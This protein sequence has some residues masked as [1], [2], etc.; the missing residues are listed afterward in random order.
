MNSS[1]VRSLAGCVLAFATAPLWAQG[2]SGDLHGPLDN[3]EAHPPLHFR[4]SISASPNGYG[5]AQIRHAYGFDQVAPTGAGQ[6]IAIIDAFG[7]GTI[8][9]DLNIFSAQYGLP[10]TTVLIYYPQG[11]P[12]RKDSGWALETSL[13]VEWAHAIAPAANI[14]LVV[15]KSASLSDLLGAVDYAVTA[16][17][18]QVSMSWGS[19]EFSS[20]ASYDSHF[21][22]PGVTFLAS[23]GDN[24]AGVE[25][26]AVSP[27]VIGVGGTSLAL[28]G[29]GN[30]V[31]ET[32]WSGSGGG[33]SAYEARPAFQSGWQAQ[34][35]R[36]VP[37]VSYDA[38]P[39]TGVSVYIGNYNGSAGWFT[40][41]GTSAGAPQWAGLVALVNSARSATMS[42]TDG[43]V[44][45]AAGANYAGNFRDITSGSNG[46]FTAAALY[47]FV[48]GLGSP[49][50][51][52]LVPALSTAP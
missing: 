36:G 18:K 9:N 26:P 20:E 33:V 15:A 51:N 44:Y 21:N 5:V 17:A 23:S 39:N 41:G 49:V 14:M 30:V 40:V 8:Q 12:R 13:D 19:N 28:D 7:S 37:D 32:A 45:S 46:A 52:Q 24:G 16:G 38:D 11:K 6:S 50:S 29:A 25:W 42:S 2:Q 4:P 27:Y 10:A 34:A 31:G 43:R 1:L 48:T 22:K 3:I 35:G 47:D